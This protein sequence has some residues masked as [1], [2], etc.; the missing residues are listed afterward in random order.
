MKYL[1]YIIGIIAILIII[2]FLLGL[3]KPEVSYDCE[4]MVDKPL[5][6][7]WSV[8]QDEGKM[9]EWL[10]G[11]QKQAPLTQEMEWSQNL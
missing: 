10:E 9:S 1:K 2:F 5:A 7:S 3:I 6:E 8:S 4:I 11:F